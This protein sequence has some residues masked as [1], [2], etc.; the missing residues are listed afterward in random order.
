MDVADAGDGN[1]RKHREP[2][3]AGQGRQNEQRRVANHRTLTRDVP[4]VHGEAQDVLEHR[5]DRGERGESHAQEEKRAPQLPQGHLLENCRKGKEHQVGARGGAYSKCEARG[6]DDQAGHDG[7]QSVQARDLHR[8]AR[9]LVVARHVAAE[10]RHRAD[11]DREHEEGLAHGRIHDLTQAGIGVVEE[12][13][14]VGKQVERKALL[15][16][17]E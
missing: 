16:A 6:E 15:R 8:L 17:V 12:I 5:D 14:E 1:T 4:L 13:V 2:Q 11:A 7:N 9:D 10:N 3:N